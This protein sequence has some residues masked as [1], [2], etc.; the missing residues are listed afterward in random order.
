MKN[1]N[2]MK[3][4]LIS[5]TV[6]LS[7][8]SASFSAANAEIVDKSVVKGDVPTANPIDN[9]DYS[10]VVHDPAAIESGFSG[11]LEATAEQIEESKNQTG[12]IN[13]DGKVDISDLSELSLALIGDK[14]LT[15]L[16]QKVADVDSDGA[17]KLTD[18]AKF[19]QFLS[20]V[21]ISLEDEDN[22]NQSD[23][24][25][26][27]TANPIDNGDYSKVERDPSTI[28]GFGGLKEATP[29]QIEE[30]KKQPDKGA[31]P[32]A[33]PIDKTDY[34]KIERD[35]AVIESG[36]SGALEATEEQMEA[37]KNLPEK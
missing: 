7:V 32:T 22:N 35:P 27:P 26:V 20:K 12:D 28:D 33:N 14:E 23:K 36:F 31:V 16:Q 29:E 2:L 10:K 34:S 13:F 1:I 6:S 17:V 19:R 30:S 37:S 4:I 3:K 24:A 15:K 5:L 21:I 11:A 9:G 25:A 18:L 8:M